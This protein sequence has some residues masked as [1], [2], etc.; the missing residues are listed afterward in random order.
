MQPSFKKAPI[1]RPGFQTSPHLDTPYGWFITGK[2]GD[3]ILTGNVTAMN[4]AVGPPNSYKTTF[5]EWQNMSA[6]DKVLA[7]KIDTTTVEYDT[8]QNKSILRISKLS[9]AFP[10]LR[11]LNLVDGDTWVITD[12]ST[13]QGGEK[14]YRL[15][16]DWLY[17]RIKEK[18]NLVVKTPFNFNLEFLS[19]VFSIFD[20]LTDFQT[21]DAVDMMDDADVG[22]KE[23]NMLGMNQGKAKMQMLGELNAI[24]PAAGMYVSFTAHVDKAPNV[25]A[26]PV[27]LPPDRKLAF[28]PSGQVIKGVG[29][30]FFYYMISCWYCA[31]STPF[32]DKD[33]KFYYPISE[34]ND[35]V[36]EGQ[37]DG[38][39]LVIVNLVQLRSKSGKSGLKKEIIISQSEGVK[40]E[41]SAFHELKTNGFGIGGSDRSYYME[42]LPDLK[43]RRTTVRSAIENNPLLRQAICLTSMLLNMYKHHSDLTP[44]LIVSPAQL[45]T[46]LEQMGYN[47]VDL[48]NTRSWWTINDYEFEIPRLTAKDLLLMRVGR[49]HPYWMDE[50]KQR[51]PEYM[52][53]AE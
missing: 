43:L 12:K 3:S 40:P 9:K 42:F 41:L 24:A 50:N 38:V 48:L 46:D 25:Q 37:D 45:K 29:S 34:D 5:I 21:T 2:Y 13:Y 33:K 10:R 11:N 31:K 52:G 18:D 15:L 14:F 53:L 36:V 16:R 27:S 8:E 35:P 17:S 20:S 6:M 19:P 1:V 51:K 23:N 30:K 49:Y 22:D 47:W 7:G 28:L 26:G 4:A 44:D 39:D 32:L